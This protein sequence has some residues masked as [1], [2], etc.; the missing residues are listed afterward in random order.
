MV[1]G[2]RPC[3]TYSVSEPVEGIMDPTVQITNGQFIWKAQN[4]V[5]QINLLQ[6]FS[7]RESKR[8]I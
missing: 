3:N 7:A 2:I 5:R 4:K 8:Y 6:Y 1:Y